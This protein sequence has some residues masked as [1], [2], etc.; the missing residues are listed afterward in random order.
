MAQAR[1][2]LEEKYGILEAL[3]HEACALGRFTEHDLYLG[4]EDHVRLAAYLNANLS[5][6]PLAAGTVPG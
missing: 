1:L 5:V 6:P 2:T 3:Y 4:L